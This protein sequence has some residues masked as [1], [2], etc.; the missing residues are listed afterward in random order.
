MARAFVARGAH[1]RVITPATPDGAPSEVWDDV[2]VER[3][4]YAGLKRFPSTGG[5]GLLV[6]V[7]R[8]RRAALSLGP[9]FVAMAQRARSTITAWRPDLVV[10]HWL[11]PAGL[12]VTRTAA[13]RV[14]HVAHSSDVHLLARAPFGRAVARAVRASGPVLATSSFLADELRARGLVDDP[15]EW[16]LGVDAMDAPPSRSVEGP[17]RVAFMGRLID[18]KGLEEL[19]DAMVGCDAR[20]SIAGDGPLRATL[21]RRVDARGVRARVSFVGP[22]SGAA[23]AAFLAHHD[24]FAH[25]PTKLEGFVD[26]LPVS[27]VEALAA[28]TPV[29]GTAVGALPELL[30]DGAGAIVQPDGVAEAL[31]SLSRRQLAPMA[32]RA[33][34]TAAQRSWPVA[35]DR[36]EAAVGH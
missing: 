14:V 20:L 10:S 31:R 12:A 17:L 11:V 36:L 2:E 4:G 3:F 7:R 5:E 8:D 21:E 25:V 9:L 19:V 22:V 15:V 33:R 16:S 13:K 27:C 26:N 1:V 34:Q 35:L 32:A 23:K 6:N 24:L 28:G 18:G 29:L 30:A